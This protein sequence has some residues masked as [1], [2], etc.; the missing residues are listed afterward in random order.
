[1]SGARAD[2]CYNNKMMDDSVPEL[3]GFSEP[4]FGILGYGQSNIGV[5]G[6]VQTTL[7]EALYPDNCAMLGDGAGPFFRSAPSAMP[8]GLAPLRSLADDARP[9]P[10]FV[11]VPTIF[12]L[13]QYCIDAGLAPRRWF[14]HASCAGGLS[15]DQLQRDSGPYAHLMT[16][17][18]WLAE[19]VPKYWPS[20]AEIAAVIVIQGEVWSENYG[21]ALRRLVESLKSDIPAKAGQVKAP[22]VIVA[23]T[24]N[25]ARFNNFDTLVLDQVAVARELDG[26]AVAGPMYYTPLD[27]SHIHGTEIG[28]LMNAEVI[29]LCLKALLVDRIAW[30]PLWPVRA[31][32]KAAQIRIEFALP[33][34]GQHLRWDTDW[35]PLQP[36][37]NFGFTYSDAVK[38]AEIRD[39]S[40][41]DDGKSVI[42][43]LD[44]I[45]T[46]SDKAL[47]YAMGQSLALEP[48]PFSAARGALIS[49][50]PQRSLFHR[51]GYA[52]PEF[53][54]HYCVRF[55][56]P[57]K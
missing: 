51:R 57:V 17:A 26:V 8:S 33:P 39:V 27:H 29:A 7:V 50:T 42:I 37:D 49:P 47:S 23:Q 5:G 3:I 48:I 15:I 53:V 30:N 35:V 46:G 20:V 12:A 10:L 4:A 45:P 54:R 16:A 52:V 40:L 25:H 43:Q 28:R 44:R 36:S 24:N 31:T 34:G 55:H 13:Q 6:D 19:L 38:S 11:T 2:C 21:P 32:R 56:Q 1:M 18:H 14:S 9:W 22:K 41:G